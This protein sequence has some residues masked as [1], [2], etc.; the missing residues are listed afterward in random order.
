MAIT[1][2][3]N[4]QISPTNSITGLFAMDGGTPTKP[5]IHSGM[6]S[7]H[8]YLN[9]ISIFTSPIYLVRLRNFE[10]KSRYPKSRRKIDSNEK[11]VAS[12]A[13]M[14]LGRRYCFLDDEVILM[15]E[16]MIRRLERFPR[17]S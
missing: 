16:F 5:G 13:M 3:L 4:V 17:R 7:H 2:V 11:P 14:E 10:S 8:K 15:S 6:F 9:S 1:L 12:A